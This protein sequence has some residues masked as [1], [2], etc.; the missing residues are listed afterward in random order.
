[1]KILSNIKWPL[2]KKKTYSSMDINP[3]EIQLDWF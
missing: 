1:M 2:K 3:E